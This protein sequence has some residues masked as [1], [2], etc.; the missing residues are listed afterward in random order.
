MKVQKG[1]TM[2]NATAANSAAVSLDSL[3]LK[4]NTDKASPAHNYLHFYEGL[5]GHLRQEPA[6]RVLEI[7]VYD[8]GSLRMWEEFFP[9]AQ[10]VGADIDPR[11]LASASNR[12]RIEIMDQSDIA[13]L[14]RVA[15]AHGPFD[16]IVDDGSHIWDHQI[17]S[18]RTLYPFVKPGG[19]YIVEDIHTSYGKLAADYRGG[20]GVSCA[21]YLHKFCDYVVADEVADV[22]QEPDAFIRS[23]ARLTDW[24]SFRRH[25]C[26]IR[27][28]AA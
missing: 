23:Y 20:A 12:S 1:R 3:G 11:T 15:V 27:R 25:T 5:I 26:V 4:H 18:L 14:T 16:L 17:T 19:T 10:L 28:N 21:D 6:P 8:G 24:M 2:N 7:G 9:N 13:Q 22:G